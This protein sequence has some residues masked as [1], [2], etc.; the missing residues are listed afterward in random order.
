MCQAGW[1]DPWGGNLLLSPRWLP[2]NFSSHGIGFSGLAHYLTVQLEKCKRSGRGNRQEVKGRREYLH[3]FLLGAVHSH[4]EEGKEL[5]PAKLAEDSLKE[6]KGVS[7]C[8]S[9]NCL[10]RLSPRDMAFTLRHVATEQLVVDMA[11]LA[12][13]L[14]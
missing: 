9:F 13:P 7:I 2:F 1:Q 6:S 3:G 12:T 8:G 5:C 14:R 10:Q 11:F 4:L